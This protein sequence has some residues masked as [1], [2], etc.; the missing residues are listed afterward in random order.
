MS[1]QGIEN[2]KMILNDIE[3]S[4]LQNIDYIEATACAQGCIGGAFCVENPYIAWHNAKMLEN[5]YSKPFDFQ[6]KEVL[7]KYKERFFFFEHHLLP[8][9]T[10][11]LSDDLPTSIKRMKQKERI[12]SKLPKKDCAL[13][14]APNC[15]TFAEDC[16]RGEA[17]ITDCIFFKSTPL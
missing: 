4:R 11:S 3:D 1:V 16:A 7:K 15:E 17:D 5:K 6:E 2:I 12:F 8:R 10:R 14:G 13:C 9:A